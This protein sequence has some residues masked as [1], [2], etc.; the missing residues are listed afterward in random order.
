MIPIFKIDNLNYKLDDKKSFKDLNLEINSGD[1]VS[2][3]APNRSGKSVLTKIICAIIPTTGVCCLDDI[4]L[5]KENVL[6]YITKIGIVT[7]DIKR[8]FLFKKVKDELSFPLEN[9]GYSNRKIKSIISK[10]SRLFEFNNLLN[11]NIN[12]LGRI[13]KSKLLIVISLLHEPKLLVLDDAFNEMDNKTKVFMLKKIKELNENGLTVLNITSNLDTV[14]DSNRIIIMNNCK[15]EKEVTLEEILKNS[16]DLEKIGIE[17][18]Y[19][20][21]LSR[22]LMKNNIIEKMFFSLDDLE[23]A[24]WK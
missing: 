10:F 19:I 4:L 13:E 8:P 7:N 5:N 23:S 15:L 20:I 9:L 12:D 21:E 17:I 24:L 14:Y 18:P 3:I 16:N 22:K 11:K 2:I 6:K 1:Y